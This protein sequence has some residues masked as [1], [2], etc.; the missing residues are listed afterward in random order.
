MLAYMVP[1]QQSS[2][3]DLTARRRQ[4][5]LDSEWMKTEAH[6]LSLPW[7]KPQKRKGPGRPTRQQKFED[8]IYNAL[9][10]KS[11]PEGLVSSAVP[12][13]WNPGMELSPP[14]MLNYLKRL[15]PDGV[16]R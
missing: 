3:D 12:R 13:W 1:K 10:N 9:V 2:V 11:L 7:P 5:E 4:Q 6:K 14:N 8:S 16:G 15:L